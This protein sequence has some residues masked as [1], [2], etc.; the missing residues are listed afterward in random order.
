LTSAAQPNGDTIAGVSRDV[1]GRLFSFGHLNKD[2]HL[3]ETLR[4]F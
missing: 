4:V 3:L 2:I 1:M